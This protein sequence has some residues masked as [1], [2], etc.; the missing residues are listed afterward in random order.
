[1]TLPDRLFY[2]TIQCLKRVP[3]HRQGHICHFPGF[4][5]LEAENNL[6]FLFPFPLK[7]LEDRGGSKRCYKELND[8]DKEA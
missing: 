7:I 5:C 2:Y 8:A 4:F 3:V 6:D 1:V